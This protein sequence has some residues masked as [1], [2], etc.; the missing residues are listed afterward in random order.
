MP[1]TEHRPFPVHIQEM[2]AHVFHR[3]GRHPQA[4]LQQ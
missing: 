4:P 2:P 3:S 1:L